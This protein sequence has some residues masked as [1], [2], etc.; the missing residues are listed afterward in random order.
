MGIVSLIVM[1]AQVAI[2][3]LQQKGVISPNTATIASAIDTA[4]PQLQAAVTS[5]TGVTPEI[6][7][8]LAVV[9][10]ALDELKQDTSLPVEVLNRLEVLSDGIQAA[11]A[12][13][14]QAAQVV[15]PAALDT[16][17]PLE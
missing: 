16:I 5:N 10:V 2:S 3:L 15:D 1:L 7:A 9:N 17:E 4:I 8:S 6:A 11:L 13:D 12:A 14:Q